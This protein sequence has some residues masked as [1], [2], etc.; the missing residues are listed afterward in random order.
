MLIL[1]ALILHW[2]HGGGWCEKRL[3]LLNHLKACWSKHL[4]RGVLGVGWLS[5]AIVGVLDLDGGYG[6]QTNAE[7]RF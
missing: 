7:G 3:L 2:L 5:R 4:V 6:G 1:K